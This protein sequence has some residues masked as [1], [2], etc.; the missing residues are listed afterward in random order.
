MVLLYN[1]ELAAVQPARLIAASVSLGRGELST[2]NRR[3]SAARI[4]SAS[5][6]L[7]TPYLI[8]S[9]SCTKHL[10]SRSITEPPKKDC[11][12][13]PCIVTPCWEYLHVSVQVLGMLLN[14][15]HGSTLTEWEQYLWREMQALALDRW[16]LPVHAFATTIRQTTEVRDG[17]VEFSAPV[18]GDLLHSLFSQLV[19]E[20]EAKLPGDCH[21]TA[22]VPV[23]PG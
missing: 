7:A 9:L 10:R 17:E 8:P 3:W 4:N 13:H 16:K 15:T 12:E 23:G 6:G 5:T 19:T 11:C 18:P 1:T 20:V 14:R 22:N 21:P 2:P